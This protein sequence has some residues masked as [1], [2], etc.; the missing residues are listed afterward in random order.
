MTRSSPERVVRR[1]VVW[2]L[3]IGFL[4]GLGLVLSNPAIALDDTTRP[5]GVADVE[6]STAFPST[7][8]VDDLQTIGYYART[9]KLHSIV[10]E[11][12]EEQIGQFFRE[13][14]SIDS[15]RLRDEIQE[16]A[17]RRLAMIEPTSALSLVSSLPS[18]RRDKLVAIVYQ[19]WSASDLDEAVEHASGLDT[20]GRAAAVEGILKAR[21]DL[22]DSVMLEIAEYLGHGQLALDAIAVSKL[23]VEVENPQE[24]LKGFLAIHGNNV[25]LLSDVQLQLLSR[26]CTSWLQRDEEEALREIHSNFSDDT[27]RILVFSVLLYSIASDSPERAFEVASDLA[28][29]N[30]SVGGRLMDDVVMQ[31]AR[32]D[33]AATL[34]ALT[35]I[36]NLAVRARTERSALSAWAAHNP[37]SLLSQL[38]RIPPLLREYGQFEA[39]RSIAR[40]SPEEVIGMFAD[41]E[42]ESNRK[43]IALTIAASW[44]ALD[45]RAAWHWIQT[46]AEIREL[47]TSFQL[48]IQQ[49][50]LQEL[51]RRGA[52]QTAQDLLQEQSN[53]ALQG[54]VIGEVA[55]SL[56][57]LEAVKMLREE[58][59]QSIRR[60]A[61]R[62]VG[63]AL[64]NEG[65]S[66]EAIKLVEEES[67]E[68]QEGYFRSMIPY[69]IDSDPQDAFSKLDLIPP[70]DARMELAVALALTN[71][72]HRTL[73]SDQ[74]RALKEIIPRT[75]HPALK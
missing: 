4:I 32:A 42:N 64:I 19:E 46:S 31:W 21:Y 51:V 3:A 7:V 47:G 28:G 54:A 55:H 11:W 12:D 34:A 18:S 73:T 74:K 26:I 30:P 37:R 41:V 22:P 24:S 27:S 71:S 36:D 16:A 67:L 57:S 1:M 6:A 69:W 56:G 29:M 20:T 65:Q 45:P 66:T 38:D 59:D 58:R 70:K 62:R 39:L 14:E 33:G 8:L 48:Q 68:Y 61:F 49:R 40:T 2:T 53:P 25:A 44:S 17:A 35:S 23:D 50:T 15:G 52:L 43:R 10:A 72:G 13:V 63:V 5:D 9:I 60:A 75:F